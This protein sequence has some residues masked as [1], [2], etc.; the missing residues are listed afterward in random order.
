MDNMKK[1]LKKMPKVMK[2]SFKKS[3]THDVLLEQ[4]NRMVINDNNLYL[5]NKWFSKSLK[6][7]MDILELNY[8][9][10]KSLGWIRPSYSRKP[11]IMIRSVVTLFSFHFYH[12]EDKDNYFGRIGKG[13]TAMCKFIFFG[14]K[15]LKYR[16]KG[17]RR[18]CMKYLSY[19]CHYL[20][21]MSEPHHVTHHIA[22]PNEK[23]MNVLKRFDINKIGK[24]NFS[25]HRRFENLAQA[26]IKGD[27]DITLLLD[28]NKDKDENILLKGVP[29]KGEIFSYILKDE[30]IKVFNEDNKKKVLDIYYKNSNLDFDDYCRYL[31][32]ESSEY[33]KEL[34]HDAFK[35]DTRE[36]ALAAIRA[37]NM[38]EIQ[39]A[40]FLYY[41]CNYNLKE[42]RF[43]EPKLKLYNLSLGVS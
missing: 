1:I 39:L 11:D 3:N 19:S 4:A 24:G 25:N 29:T 33:A 15:A 20:A 30:G 8:N 16:Y 43:V 31:G 17:K 22:S 42:E 18:K 32:N 28:K 26:W 38:A 41:F 7:C 13:K 2:K 10:S 27:E 23:I 40:R 35:D 9:V 34:I 6:W 5:N 36:Q 12:G 14:R 37:L 21:D